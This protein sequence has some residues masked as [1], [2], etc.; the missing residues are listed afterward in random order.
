MS[1]RKHRKRLSSC[2]LVSAHSLVSR[3]S[4]PVLLNHVTRIF[5]PCHFLRHV[6]PPSLVHAASADSSQAN[7]YSRLRVRNTCPCSR[8]LIVS[9]L[10]GRSLR[11]PIS[12][13]FL[14][15]R[16]RSTSWP[17]TEAG[18][19]DSEACALLVN[20]TVHSA[21]SISS[22]SRLQS[23]TPPIQLTSCIQLRRSVIVERMSDSSISCF[24]II[25]R[26]Q[27]LAEHIL[28]T[29]KMLK[30]LWVHTKR[31]GTSRFLSGC[32][33]MERGQKQADLIAAPQ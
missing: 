13:R 4:I 10:S 9:W 5:P 26:R 32:G 28:K 21:K 25:C 20:R 16:A 12:S 24:A 3:V 1:S 33:V 15:P 27:S 7:R 17:Q 29:S 31:C 22:I 11:S 18:G 30:K 23:A 6:V 19:D 14:R 2:S 8:R